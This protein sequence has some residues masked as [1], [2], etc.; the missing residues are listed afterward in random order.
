MYGTVDGR[1]TN[2]PL[3]GEGELVAARHAL[4]DNVLVLHPGRGERF[5]DAGDKRVDDARVPPRVDYGD[6]QRRAYSSS[7]VQ[8]SP[9]LFDTSV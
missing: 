2:E 5:L 9:G 6:A 7:V 1:G 8:L 4:R 3:D